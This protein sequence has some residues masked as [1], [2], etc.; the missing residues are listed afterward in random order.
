MIVGYE[1][2]IDEKNEYEYFSD[3]GDAR[4]KAEEYLAKGHEIYI[5]YVDKF[6]EEKYYEEL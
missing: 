5:S 4:D 1:L 6:G 2:Y 3:L